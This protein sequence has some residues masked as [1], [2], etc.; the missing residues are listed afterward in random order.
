MKRILVTGALVCFVY[1]M[2][3]QLAIKVTPLTFPRNMYF[4]G[5]VEY[6]IPGTP[7]VSAAI[8]V[9]P[10]ISYSL[11]EDTD[12]DGF[13]YYSKDEEI[14]HPGFSIDPEVRIYQRKNMEGAYAGLYGS[15]RSSWG[16]NNEYTDRIEDPADTT[17][18]TYLY[19]NATGG[20]QKFNTLIT[21]VGVQVGYQKFLG[22]GDRIL[23]DFYAGFGKKI[24]SRNYSSDQN[25]LGSGLENNVSSGT[26]IESLALRAN[27][28]IGILLYKGNE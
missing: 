10:N 17:G 1:L 27:V 5:H 19:L 9:S 8:G 2:Q 13:Y 22:P 26:G 7:R 14:S 21:V 16:T 12:N 25:L 24:I 11:L 15:F 23:F 20:T 3:A 4:T 28:S 18:T 6:L